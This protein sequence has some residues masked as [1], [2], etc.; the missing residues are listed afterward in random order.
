MGA[1][2]PWRPWEGCLS[3]NDSWGYHA[4]DQNWKSPGQV[5]DLL[6]SAAA[7]RGNLLLNVSPRG[8]G[9]L[10]PESIDLLRTVGA[11]LRRN[12]KAIYPSSHVWSMDLRERGAHRG[13]WNSHGSCTVTGN[14]LNVLVK[15]WPG[16]EMILG[17][18]ECTVLRAQIIGGPHLSVVQQASRVIISGLPESPP[19]PHCTVIRLECDRIPQIY[20]CGGLRVPNVPHPHYDPCPSELLGNPGGA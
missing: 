2:T 15:R 4:G 16:S 18:L 7:G 20:Q 12:G 8:D 19:D 1:P 3:V 13:D 5:I 10:Q 6:A 14:F 9:S 17:G 11:W